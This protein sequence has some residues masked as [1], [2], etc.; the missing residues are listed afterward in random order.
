MHAPPASAADAATAAPGRSHDSTNVIDTL[1]LA[2]AGGRAAD[3]ALEGNHQ[4]AM[5]A[6]IGADLQQARRHDAIKAGP[7][8]PVVGMVQLAGH[9]RHQGDDIGFALGQ[10]GDIARQCGVIDFASG[11]CRGDGTIHGCSPKGRGR[12]IPRPHGF[13]Q[14]APPQFRRY[15]SG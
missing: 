14:S 1:H 15:C 3:A 9:C 8:E 13:G 7:V 4:T 2:R 6:L 11:F 10:G 12:A 5:A